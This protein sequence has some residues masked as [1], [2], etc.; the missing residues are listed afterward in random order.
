VFGQDN[1]K[2]S[3]RLTLELGARYD[4]EFLPSPSANLTGPTGS[5]VPFPGVTN[6]PSDKNN[7][8][9]RIGFADDVF[10]DGKTVLRGG[11]GIF[12][13]RITNGVLLNTLLNTGSPNG[14]Y[15]SQF[16][17]ATAGAPVFP[18]IVQ[19]ASGTVAA[20]GV[21]YL[22]P[23]LQNPQV[24]EYDL[25]LQ[26]EIGR[27][28]IFSMSYLGALGRELPNFLDLNLD[29]TTVVP[30]TITVSDTSGKGPLPNGA[31]YVVPTYTKYG[32]KGLFGSV[33]TNFQNITE[34]VS[35]VNSTYNA[36]VAEVQNRSIHNL[37][38]D[39]N[40]TWAHALDF[41][42]NATTTTSANSWYDPYSNA[43][44]NYGNSN[45]NVPTRF[46]GYALYTFPVIHS[47]AWYTYASNGWSIDTSFQAQSG[48]P[49][50]TGVSGFNSNDAILGDWN[51]AGGT[52]AIPG[53]GLNTNRQP[54]KIV[55]DM[56]VQK[57]FTFA[58][59]YNLQLLAN[60]FNIANHQNIDGV[61]ATAY[62][63]SSGA[64]GN[65]GVATFQPATFAVPT[66]SN[67][68]GFLYTPRQIEIGARFV[69]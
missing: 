43:R 39:F 42:Q 4:Y 8:G 18:N 52:T 62:K 59:K 19:A 13:G 64:A 33:A 66:S 65:L 44:A 31:Q 16:K 3:P 9:V 24:H 25:V 29:P 10:G 58:E 28:T 50:T 27:G 34:V 57:Q 14:Q 53:I 11:Y 48:L 67:N 38:F 23:H 41:A 20:P 54:R 2:I 40:F 7:V 1:W 69:F 22:G 68:S 12:Y 37:Q 51:G 45:Y 17:P 26:Q 32:N 56:R 47:S 21:Y 35:N 46:V 36:L 6:H 30:V 60:V 49:Y 15:T 63:L 5:Y 61:G 55:D